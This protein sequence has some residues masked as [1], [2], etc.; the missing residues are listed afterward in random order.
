MSVIWGTDVYLSSMARRQDDISFPMRLVISWWHCHVFLQTKWYVDHFVW[1]GW[2]CFPV[3]R[4]VDYC[5][6][7]LY[8]FFVDLG[9]RGEQPDVCSLVLNYLHQVVHLCHQGLQKINTMLRNNHLPTW[10]RDSGLNPSIQ[11]DRHR[12]FSLQEHMTMPPTNK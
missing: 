10:V 9:G 4:W 8:W 1:M 3:L 5:F 7:T 2:F 11:N 12:P 6:V